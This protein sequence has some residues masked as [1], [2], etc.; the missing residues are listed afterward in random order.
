M[1]TADFWVSFSAAQER[2]A[3]VLATVSSTRASRMPLPSTNPAMPPMA[4]NWVSPVPPLLATPYIDR[5]TGRFEGIKFPFNYPPKNVSPSHP[6]TNFPWAASGTV[7]GSE[8][9]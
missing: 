8:F 7:S 1:L 5:P 4:Q 3:Y 6:F 9:Y 2:Q